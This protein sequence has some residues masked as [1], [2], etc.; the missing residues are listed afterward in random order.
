MFAM[1]GAELPDPEAFY[2]RMRQYGIGLFGTPSTI[3]DQLQRIADIG[4]QHVA[5]VSRFGGIPKEAAHRS[6][7]MLA[8]ATPAPANPTLS[9]A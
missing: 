7:E 8:P 3:A 2:E 5:F 9:D 4:V 1:E 6:L